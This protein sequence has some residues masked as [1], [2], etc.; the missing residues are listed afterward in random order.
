MEQLLVYYKIIQFL[1][2]VYFYKYLGPFSEDI[3]PI[4]VQN[5]AEFYSTAVSIMIYFHNRINN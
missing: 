1:F 2:V 4:L 5:G 3:T